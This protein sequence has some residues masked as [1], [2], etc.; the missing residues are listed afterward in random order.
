M[1][2][3]EEIVVPVASSF[4]G[5]GWH[6]EPRASRLAKSGRQAMQLPLTIDRNGVTA[7]QIQIYGQIRQLILASRLT[8]GVRV[9]AT[10]SLAAE[11]GVSRNTIVL[12]YDRLVSEGYLETRPA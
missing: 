10:R 2:D 11:L 8:P 9:P 7:L 12:A 5:R 6:R 3:P 4:P 1:I